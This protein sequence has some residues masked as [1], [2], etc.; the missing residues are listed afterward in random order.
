MSQRVVPLPSKLLPLWLLVILPTP[1]FAANGLVEDTKKSDAECIEGIKSRMAMTDYTYD[2]NSQEPDNNEGLEGFTVLMAAANNEKVLCFEHLLTYN[3]DLNLK[4]A[5]GRTALTYAAMRG[6]DGGENRK[7]AMWILE[8][9]ADPSI[10]D[11]VGKTP[12]MYAAN[13]GHMDVAKQL[14]RYCAK[15]DQED[16]FGETALYWAGN[17]EWVD[18]T[19]EYEKMLQSATPKDECAVAPTPAPAPPP[20]PPPP[21]ADSGSTSG[22]SGSTSDSAGSA[23]GTSSDS[24]GNANGGT[25]SAGKVASASGATFFQG[26][27]LWLS[28]LCAVIAV[29]KSI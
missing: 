19:E 23:S 1:T 7:M 25:T 9:G 16:D 15:T 4:D 6:G 2:I 8:A 26:G 10:G 21:P 17:G 22:S 3:P 29:C 20:P 27:S 12:L 24:S 13:V 5:K 11:K 14:I 28:I 18:W